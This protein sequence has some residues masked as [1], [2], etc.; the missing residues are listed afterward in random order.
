MFGMRDFSPF[1]RFSY[2]IKLIPVKF[3]CRKQTL[4]EEVSMDTR[5]V[6]CSIVEFI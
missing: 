6:R 1:L 3:L 5:L 2:K 4:S